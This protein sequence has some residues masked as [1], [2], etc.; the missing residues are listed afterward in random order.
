MMVL[1]SV[2]DSKAEA[3]A[4]PFVAATKGVAVR[5]WIEA[6]NTPEHEFC[7]FSTDYALFEL[8]TF[9]EQTGLLV[10]LAVPK[11]LGL[12]QEYRRGTAE[13]M[14]LLQQ[15]RMNPQGGE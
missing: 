14:R 5:Q 7:K 13:E 11:S 12:A 9:D 10:P 8:A 6:C 15:S 2:Y 4:R 3:F 1:F